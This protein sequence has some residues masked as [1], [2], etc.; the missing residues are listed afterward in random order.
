MAFSGTR[1]YSS[2]RGRGSKW[3]ILLAILLILVILGSVGFILAREHMSYGTD[4]KLHFDPPWAKS[5]ASAGEDAPSGEVII[6]E[7]ERSTA[8]AMQGTLLPAAPLTAETLAEAK[9]QSTGSLVITLKDDTG[10]VYFDSAA[11]LAGMV[12][13]ADTT[14]AAL[15]ELTGGG[16][17]T[18]AKISCFH[19]PKAANADV[20]GMGL[21]NTG[22]YIFYDGNNSQWLDPGKAVARDYVC[23]IARE[24]AELGFDELILTDVSYPTA[25]KLDKIDLSNA[26]PG[27]DGTDGRQLVLARFLREVRSVL[28][29]GVILSLELPSE[30]VRAG[31]DTDAGQ[32]LSALAPLVDRVYVRTTAAEVPALETA[33]KAASATCGFVPELTERPAETVEN[34]LIIEN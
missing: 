22:G 24:A 19:D 2:Y 8:E 4:G 6:Q 26:Q 3:K 32:A 15:A 5:D 27:E 12:S 13:T 16:D 17:H 11:A 7:P 21:K 23:G 18:A 29:E 10:A 33:V 25:G 20:D 31:Y 28:P 34:W 30:T 1:G 14:A 9:A